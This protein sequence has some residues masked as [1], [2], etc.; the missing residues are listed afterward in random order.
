MGKRLLARV[1][2]AT[3]LVMAAGLAV[4][5][6]SADAAV[7]ARPGSDFNGDGYQDLAIGA[8]GGTVGGLRGAGYVT[9]LYGSKKGLDPARG[10]VVTQAG[11]GVPDDPE[12]G[13]G[14]GHSVAAGDFNGDGFADL[15][16]GATGESIEG[17]SSPGSVTVLFGGTEGLGRGYLIT[18]EQE[19][20]QAVAAGDINGDGQMELLTSADVGYVTGTVDVY[21]FPRGGFDD[22]SVSVGGEGWGGEDWISTGDVNGDGYADVLAAW[23]AVGGTPFVTYLPGSPN[24][25]NSDA[26][27]T[28]DGGVHLAAGDIDRDGHA[29]LVTG[30]PLSPPA[31][32]AV[33]GRIEVRYGTANGFEGSRTQMIDQS[34]SGVPGTAEYGDE[35]GSA[36][37]VG[38]VTGDG[39]PD[40]AV[41]VQSKTVGTAG[42]AGEVVL[43]RGSAGGLT[44]GHA[45]AFSQDS[46][47]VPDTAEQGDL[48][49]WMVTLIDHNKDGRADLTAAAIGEDRSW[50][51]ATYGAGMVT[52]LRGARSGLSTGNARTFGP[53]ALGQDA[54]DAYFGWSLTP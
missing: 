23:T 30:Q 35:F 54:T 8:Q 31:S 42:R 50:D 1:T 10:E 11:D 33:G 38:D 34:T 21:H 20:G 2:V 22:P 44:G 45:Q 6:G 3:T 39:Y 24:G 4:T 29:D 36:V 47:G 12:E 15:A 27:T 14:F 32:D 17:N 28:V 52:T 19:N 43:L 40:V 26:M 25:I 9:V 16:I 53:A 46:P 13:D 18:G 37:A 48:L 7:L 41:G 51:G 5:Q 49:G